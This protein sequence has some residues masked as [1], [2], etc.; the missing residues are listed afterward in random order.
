MLN[1][2]LIV[3]C[4]VLCPVDCDMSSHVEL[5]ALG[6]ALVLS[7]EGL[8]GTTFLAQNFLVL[9]DVGCSRLWRSASFIN[10]INIA[11]QVFQR[12][13]F[14]KCKPPERD[15]SF[16]KGMFTKYV[17]MMMLGKAS[18]TQKNNWNFPIEVSTPPLPPPT[19][20]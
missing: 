19:P 18:K 2:M 16:Q 14:R 20:N 9:P 10:Q 3:E 13:S 5:F 1:A 4:N 11:R 7:L 17:S 15:S 8:L 6:L 12:Q